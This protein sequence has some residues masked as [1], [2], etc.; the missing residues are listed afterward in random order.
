MNHLTNATSLSKYL[1]QL[2][3][4]HVQHTGVTYKSAYWKVNNFKN[5]KNDIFWDIM[6]YENSNIC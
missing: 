1:Q 5:F 3:G 4:R 2:G 6:L